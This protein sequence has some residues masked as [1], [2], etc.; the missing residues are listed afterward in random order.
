M[1]LTSAVWTRTVLADFLTLNRHGALV[2][3]SANLP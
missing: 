2:V 1:I 3:G